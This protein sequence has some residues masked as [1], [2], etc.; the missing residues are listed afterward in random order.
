MHLS[1][2]NKTVCLINAEETAVEVDIFPQG[3]VFLLRFFFWGGGRAVVESL[4]FFLRPKCF[5][6]SGSKTNKESIIENK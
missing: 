3:V 5:I 2:V 1:W 4:F 6:D